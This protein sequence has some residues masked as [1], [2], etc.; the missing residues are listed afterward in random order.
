[1]DRPGSLLRV[2]NLRAI[3][4]FLILSIAIRKLP[5]LHPIVFIGVGALVGI[6]FRF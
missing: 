5:K 2:L 4:L 3:A 1:M 6:V